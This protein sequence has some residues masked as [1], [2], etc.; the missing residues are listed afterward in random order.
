MK[1]G[2]ASVKNAT[3]VRNVC[4]II[5]RHQTK[6]LLVVISAMDKTTNHLEQLAR[7]AR[8]VQ[9]N[10]AWKQL[11]RIREFH[12]G[13]AKEL[14][15]NVPSE[16]EGALDTYFMEIERIIRGLLLL[17]EFPS[18]TYDRIVSYGELLSTTLVYH[19]LMSTGERPAW[20]DA[21]ELI[22]TDASY[23]QARVIWSLT[24]ENIQKNISPLFRHYKVI[25]TQGFIASNTEGKVTTLGREGSDYTAAIFA[26]TLDAEQVIVWKDV[27]GILN[28][29]PKIT[30]NPTKLEKLSYEEAV[31]MTFYGATVIHPKTIKP[32]F[33]KQIPMYVKCFEDISESGTLISSSNA[34]TTPNT[35]TSTIIKG[36]QILVKVTPRD[37]SFM[38]SDQ[39]FGIFNAVARSGI[40]V[41]LV[42]TSAISLMLCLDNKT[43]EIEGFVSLLLDNFQIVQE[44]GLTLTTYLNFTEKERSGNEG[45]M[46]IQQAGNKLFVLK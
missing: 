42:Q 43:R 10:E 14:F 24:Q 6:P 8:D 32:L 3:G 36:N 29:D 7:L 35:I 25:I 17:A 38:E 31:E 28:A 41:N 19:Y 16:L 30:K 15:E 33:T 2:G 18:R 44:K 46:M 11:S 26:N 13:I 40:R 22:K 20:A 21:R 1:F 9:E 5:R 39:L 45:A 4:E 27:K 12:F 23:T 34:F 37:F